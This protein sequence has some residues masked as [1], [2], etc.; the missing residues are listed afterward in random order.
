MARI[1][2]YGFKKY[3]EQ[4]ENL[5]RTISEIEGHAIYEG[6]GLVA[7]AVREGID[8]IETGGDSLWE[9][10]RREKQKQ[11][12][13][14]GFGIAPLRDDNGF[15]NVKLGFNGYNSGVTT[16]K[17]PNGQ[18]N[19]MVARVFNSGTSHNKKQPFFDKAV[20]KMRKPAQE[21]MKEVF[22]K[23]IDEIMKG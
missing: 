17:F 4:L 7:D 11:G 5:S 19:V 23:E 8:S 15:L 14:E 18:P 3:E 21:K 12:L 10:K 6:A 13:K 1:K 9:K 22:E 2:I 16:K 20:R